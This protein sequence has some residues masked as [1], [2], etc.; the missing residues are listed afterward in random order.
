MAQ[1]ANQDEDR[2]EEFAD[3][4]DGADDIDVPAEAEAVERIEADLR[5]AKAA[6]AEGADTG[7][8]EAV[9]DE[10]FEGADADEAAER[11]GVDADAADT[12]VDTDEAA[13]DDRLGT[14]AE[15]EEL[16]PT[17]RRIK[18]RVPADKIR[19]IF[20][21]NW[22]ELGAQVQR[23]GFRKGRVPR[24]LLERIVGSKFMEE[25]EKNLKE[26]AIGE[27]AKDRGLYMVGTP[28]FARAELAEGAP[29]EFEAVVEVVPDFALPPLEDIEVARDAVA[30]SDEEVDAQLQ[31]L[32]REHA[33]LAV[34]DVWPPAEG[35]VVVA[36]TKI[37][38]GGKVIVQNDG[39]AVLVGRNDVYGLPVPDLKDKL[40]AGERRI[41]CE[42]QVPE[43]N[44]N[45]RLRARRVRIE[46]E[47]GEVK[48]R[49]PPELTDEWAGLF[50]CAN[51]A[52]LRTR[53]AE[54][55]RAQKEHAAERALGERAFERIMERVGFPIPEGVTKRID[56]YA[57][58]AMPDL[59]AI[60]A[61]E[62]TAP[63]EDAGADAAAA[64]AAEESRKRA[65]AS[66]ELREAAEKV[67]RR[68]VVMDRLAESH[69]IEVGEDDVDE[70][71]QAAQGVRGKELVELKRRLEARGAMRRIMQE[72]LAVKVYDHLRRNCRVAVEEKKEERP[73]EGAETPA[74]GGEERA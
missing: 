30:V 42:I 24:R 46:L 18:G 15:V 73:A 51:V 11:E 22:R 55:I 5:A 62:G 41:D 67:F 65:E 21:E 49:T 71:L 32:L 7:K 53:I 69:K 19:E 61:E 37:T 47:A 9:E 59:E 45:E 16:S 36:A 2:R 13:E 26:M 10:R 50:K 63:A 12:D 38:S 39:N 35:D 29:F 20:K 44:E 66:A 31:H 52:E 57:P 34:V 3:G 60:R 40:L 74:A 17:A 54:S 33:D 8:D 25:L 27:V 4:A 28:E 70:Y 68:Q 23:R 72:L 64:A 43:D 56:E 14:E 6:A 58:K 48:R 1:E